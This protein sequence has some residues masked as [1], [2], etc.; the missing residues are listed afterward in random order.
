M[1]VHGIGK[2]KKGYLVAQKKNQKLNQLD[3]ITFDFDG[4]PTSILL[5]I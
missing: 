4:T 2:I 1:Y 3:I 5:K